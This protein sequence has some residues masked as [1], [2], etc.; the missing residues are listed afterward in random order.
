MKKNKNKNVLFSLAVAIIIGVAVAGCATYLLYAEDDLD[1]TMP[2]AGEEASAST[3][4][5]KPMLIE[6]MVIEEPESDMAADEEEASD[7]VD[8]ALNEGAIDNE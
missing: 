3:I 6:E 4:Q 7:E 2:S 5:E 8:N 1:Q